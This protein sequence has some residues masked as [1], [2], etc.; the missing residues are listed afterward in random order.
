VEDGLIKYEYTNK[1]NL[2]VNNFRSKGGVYT[3]L[4]KIV[5]ALNEQPLPQQPLKS[6]VK[7]EPSEDCFIEKID[8]TKRLPDFRLVP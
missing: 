3:P 6:E 2:R 1:Y 7:L 8:Y 5:N 4:E